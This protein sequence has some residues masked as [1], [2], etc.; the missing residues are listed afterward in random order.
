MV[1]DLKAEKERLEKEKQVSK[2]KRDIKNKIDMLLR[3]IHPNMTP[4]EDDVDF[5]ELFQLNEIKK[6]LL[7]MLNQKLTKHLTDWFKDNTDLD[8]TMEY[9]QEQ[10]FSKVKLPI[11]DKYV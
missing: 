3:R 7:D 2:T 1:E 8:I 4:E 5:N 9:L 6:S 10:G 11:T